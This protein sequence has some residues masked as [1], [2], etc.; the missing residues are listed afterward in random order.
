MECVRGGRCKGSHPLICKDH[1]CAFNMTQPKQ[2]SAEALALAV[3]LSGH[4]HCQCTT[5]CEGCI[6]DAQTIDRELALPQRNAALLLAQQV[7]D[8]DTYEGDIGSAFANFK[9]LVY[10]LRDALAAIPKTK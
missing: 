4:T 7:C 1:G 6:A 3:R 2:P 8:A 5:P 9:D 10:Q